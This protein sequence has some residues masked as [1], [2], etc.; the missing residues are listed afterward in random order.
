V[1]DD[2]SEEHLK[3]S[4]G[5]ITLGKEHAE[6]KLR[7]SMEVGCAEKGRGERDLFKA[8]QQS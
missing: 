6:K 3:R 2:A 8:H 1:D 7:Q 5:E 4:V